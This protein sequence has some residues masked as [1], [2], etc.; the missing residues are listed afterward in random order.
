M[1]T[2][3]ETEFGIS[4]VLVGETRDF[5]NLMNALFL[6]GFLVRDIFD[7]FIP[8]IYFVCLQ[9]ILSEYPFIAM[10]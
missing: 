7:I 9:C 3:N 2:P 8:F 1:D 6:G 5:G 10:Q 4:R